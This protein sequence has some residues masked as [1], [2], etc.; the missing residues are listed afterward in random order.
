MIYGSNDKKIFLELQKYNKTYK[1]D[2][3]SML[4]LSENTFDVY[5]MHHLC[6]KPKFPT[7]KKFNGFYGINEY[8]D[9][10]DFE[11]PKMSPFFYENWIVG[12][13]GSVLN[14]GEVLEQF[15]ECDF[16]V[17]ENSSSIVVAM[18][19]AFSVHKS[20]KEVEIIKDV[21]S[22]LEGTYSCWIYNLRTKNGFLT[23]CNTDLYA[24]IY[25]NSFSSKEVKGFE[26]LRDGEIYQLT[27]EGVTSVG[28]FDCNI[29]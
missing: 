29:H 19:Y 21:F 3:V 6:K 15:S 28:Y 1:T 5:K 18:L 4:L 20:E 10:P 13:S 11:P 26:T 8:G 16:I 23:K 24:D 22:L 9:Y 12:Y 2:S 27:R 17:H 14:K 7:K 25:N